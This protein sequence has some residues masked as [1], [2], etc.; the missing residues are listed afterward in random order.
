MT[1]SALTDRVDTGTAY[2]LKQ[3]TYDAA[4][5]EVG[6]G[7][8]GGE[9]LRRYWQ[10]VALSR[11]VS[12][13]PKNVRLLGEDLIL[14]RTRRGRAGLVYPR[15]IH[16][17]STLAYGKVED[18]G[19][20]CNYHGWLF[21]PEGHTLDQP[22]EPDGG[23]KKHK[24]RQPWY[25]VEERYGIVFAYM[26][27]PERKPPLPRY[28]ILE[29]VPEGRVQIATDR[30]RIFGGPEILPANWVQSYEN[31]VDP[32]HV[33]V[34]HSTL[35]GTQF[36]RLLTVVPKMTWEYS[37]IGLR[38][39][40]RRTLEDGTIFRRV[41][42]L[43]LPNAW[44]VA[45]PTDVEFG[46][47]Q[48]VMWHQP[49]DDTHTRVFLVKNTTPELA[50]G[51]LD[52][53]RMPLYDGNTKNWWELDEEGH[54]RYPGDYEAQAGQGPITL[55][56]EEHLASSDRGVSMY[57]RQ[58]KQIIKAVEAGEQPM[59]ADL[60]LITITAGNYL[61]KPTGAPQPPSPSSRVGAPPAR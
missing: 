53:S 11:Q 24:Y 7:T 30:T 20:R 14:F 60:T 10:P 52:R 23:L 40:S 21:G 8:P 31:V 16:R 43:V 22:C 39:I 61:D 37:E 3:G 41:S 45:P 57:R 28:S 54:Q 5:T 18:D 19:I 38:S 55:H 17:G 51:W 25:P 42:E 59:N 29:N 36:S 48:E 44:I 6:P 32:W 15:C 2:G 27:P 58:W 12:D 9:A 49:I 46:P 4:L 50:E 56:S 1:D 33:Y 47:C 35:T 13:L 26:G 34:L